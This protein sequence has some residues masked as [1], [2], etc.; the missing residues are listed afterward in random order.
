MLYRVPLAMS[1]IQTL[2][3]IGT[4]CIGNYHMITTQGPLRKS[5]YSHQKSCLSGGC[6]MSNQQFFFNYIM[7]RTSDDDDVR[8]VLDLHSQ[9]DCSCASSQ[10]QQAAGIC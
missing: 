6:L 4:D 9:L 8:F 5:L 10:K 2:M 3:V 7:A 1:G